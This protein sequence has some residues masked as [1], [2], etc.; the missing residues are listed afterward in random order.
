M[1]AIQVAAVQQ[2]LMVAALTCNEIEHFNAFQTGFAPELR[3]WDARLMK[4]FQRLFGYRQGQG[5][6]HAF[7]TR[8]ANNSSIRS[9]RNNPDFCHEAGQVFAAALV[10][11]KPTLEAFVAGIPVIDQGPVDSCEVRTASGLSGAKA[12]PNVVSQPN[13]GGVANLGAP[14][15]VPA[16]VPAAAQ[17]GGASATAAGN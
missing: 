6:Y 7:K 17:P 15:S 8:L 4:M 11:Q 1:T 16:S 2:E 10:S 12:I 9:I 5:E 3:V 14:Q 13:P